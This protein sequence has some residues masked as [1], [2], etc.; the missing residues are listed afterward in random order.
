MGEGEGGMFQENSIWRERVES[1]VGGGIGM[2]KTCKLKKK[3]TKKKKRNKKKKSDLEVK[4]NKI[5]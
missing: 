2:G 4:K 5:K 1:E 3:I